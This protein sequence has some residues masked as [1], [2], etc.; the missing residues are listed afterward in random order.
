MRNIWRSIMTITKE[1]VLEVLR[2]CFDPEIPVNIYDLGLIY[3]IEIP[4]D[5]TVEITMTLTSI[6]CPSAQAIPMDISGK[7]TDRLGVKN[8]RVSV[9]WE[10][11]W[12]PE[13]ITPAGRLKLGLDDMM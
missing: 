12:S 9:V 2:D 1:Q 4:N 11:M 7:L 8:P 5:D 3:G 10:P 6:G 13:K